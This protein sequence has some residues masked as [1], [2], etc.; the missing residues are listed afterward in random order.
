MTSLRA[1]V[2]LQSPTSFRSADTGRARRT[3]GTSLTLHYDACAVDDGLDD[4]FDVL[5]FVGQRA[6]CSDVTFEPL[7]VVAGEGG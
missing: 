4:A 7:K 6:S 2:T 5:D 1:A 3:A